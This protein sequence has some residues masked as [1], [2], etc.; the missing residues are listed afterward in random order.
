MSP[1]VSRQLSRLALIR[2]R[3][4]SSLDRSCPHGSRFYVVG[5]LEPSLADCYNFTTPSADAP[6]QMYGTPLPIDDTNAMPLFLMAFLLV[7]PCAVHEPATADMH[8]VFELNGWWGP[9][10]H[11]FRL[12]G[13]GPASC[14]GRLHRHVIASPA[15]QRSRGQDHLLV[16][17]WGH[18]P[19]GVPWVTPDGRQN[20]PMK[21]RAGEL[22]PRFRHRLDYGSKVVI[23]SEARLDFVGA[24]NFVRLFA[25]GRVAMNA[26]GCEEVTTQLSG[27]VV[28]QQI[29]SDSTTK[30]RC[31]SN[32]AGLSAEH[33]TLPR[34]WRTASALAQAGP[35][36]RCR[37]YRLDFSWRRGMTLPHIE[38]PAAGAFK[39]SRRNGLKERPILASGVWGARDKNRELRN[40]LRDALRATPSC[41]MIELIEFA[42]RVA[43]DTALAEKE[44][45]LKPG[46][47][48][49]ANRSIHALYGA[50]RFCIVP[51]GD[52][53]ASKRLTSA[54]FAGCVP[55]VCSDH[56]V[57][58]FASVISWRDTVLRVPELECANIIRTKL[59]A[60]TDREW[61]HLHHHTLRAQRHL[62]FDPHKP[63]AA[64]GYIQTLLQ[65]AEPI[66]RTGSLQHDGPTAAGVPTEENVWSGPLGRT[67]DLVVHT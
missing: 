9:Y 55:V 33:G 23:A 43:T 5:A 52:N 53:A 62:L 35:N 59:A 45:N 2:Q 16:D 49:W 8:F 21:A 14:F 32:C 64:G 67:P 65:E 4:N 36:P 18:C 10:V 42:V 50:S 34:V 13:L 41:V 12:G 11:Q 40:Q 1:F 58:P 51:R 60:I 48:A 17:F 27:R 26:S 44:G 61:L 30:T 6:V 56:Y 19:P 47:D 25:N 22:A 28:T 20:Y 57:L 15:W 3:Y 46:M 63:D 29:S 39:L 66:L 54:I 31:A 38:V 24:T 37:V 7:H